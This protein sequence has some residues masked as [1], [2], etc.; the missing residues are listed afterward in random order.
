VLAF[1]ID[2]ALHG[3]ALIIK[4]IYHTE[5]KELAPPPDAKR[6]DRLRRDRR[7]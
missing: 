5:P 1:D 6:V 7:A 4:L 2:H 3:K